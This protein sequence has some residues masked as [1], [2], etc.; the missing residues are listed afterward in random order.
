MYAKNIGKPACYSVSALR[1]I[2]NNADLLQDPVVRAMA[3]RSLRGK[4]YGEESNPAKGFYKR[5]MGMMNSFG[6]MSMGGSY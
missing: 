6:T 1:V 5:G 4:M 2:G 3:D